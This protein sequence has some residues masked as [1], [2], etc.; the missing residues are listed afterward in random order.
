MSVFVVGLGSNLGS[1]EAFLR[2][3]IRL[4]GQLEG[5]RV[6]A[7]SRLYLTPPVGPP[8]PDYLNA[9]LRL[10]TSLSPL[11]LLDALLDVELRLGRVR[12]ER[13][14]P[15]VLDLDV[16]A[17]SGDAL[18]HPRLRVP[19]PHLHE[20]PFALFPLMDVAPELA[21]G[22]PSLPPPPT[23]PWAERPEEA[24]DEADAWALAAR[25]W[26]GEPAEITRVEP[27]SVADPRR[28]PSSPTRALVVLATLGPDGAS[29]LRLA[30][31]G[32]PAH[33]GAALL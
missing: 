12:D 22:Q 25:D 10:S 3:A 8:Q 2:A 9:A 5:A 23:R 11:V 15:R 33:R 14:G 31:A 13:W 28:V 29:G 26:W 17:W 27:L 18:D 16:L 4:V 6:E 32:E 20:R 7:R 24:L 21:E 19:H 1:R 30:G